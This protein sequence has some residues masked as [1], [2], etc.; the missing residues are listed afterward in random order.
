MT[1]E[2]VAACEGAN[3]AGAV[4]IRVKDAHYSGR[5]IIQDLLPKILD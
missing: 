1:Q 3:D 4:E 2:V 5:N